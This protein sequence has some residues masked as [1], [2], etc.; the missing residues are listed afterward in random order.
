MKCASLTSESYCAFFGNRTSYNQRER[1]FST[2]EYALSHSG[3][4]CGGSVKPTEMEYFVLNSSGKGM[5]IERVMGVTMGY[6]PKVKSPGNPLP[7]PQPHVNFEITM[8]IYSSSN[9]ELCVLT[10]FYPICIRIDHIE[11]YLKNNN[12]LG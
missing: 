5:G 2:L 1:N 8:L 11:N 7:N 3:S 10:V 9:F 6:S 4:T 12:N